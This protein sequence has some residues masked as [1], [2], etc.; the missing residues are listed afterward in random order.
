MH[1][2][3]L[4]VYHDYVNHEHFVPK[5]EPNSGDPDTVVKSIRS[6]GLIYPKFHVEYWSGRI[7]EIA[8]AFTYK[9]DWYP[10]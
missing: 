6:R 9:I 4:T 1:I 8:G 5:P 2:E 7:L 3:R 10:D